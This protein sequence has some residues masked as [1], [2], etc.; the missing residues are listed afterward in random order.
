[1]SPATL[2]QNETTA[3]EPTTIDQMP[4]ELDSSNSKLVYLY[5][6]TVEEAS[7]TDLRST[8]DMKQL[9]LFPVLKMLE[10]EGLIE[11]DGETF[12]IAA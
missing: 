6:E 5:L 2:T 12:T 3:A 10:G 8:L 1:M 9:A 4:A 11:R 7:I